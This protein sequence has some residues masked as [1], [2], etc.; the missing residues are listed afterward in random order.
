MINFDLPEDAETYT[1][2]VGRTGRAGAEGRALTFV[3][4][5]QRKE[6]HAMARSLE[7]EGE[8]RRGLG[9]EPRGER[10]ERH[11]H[12]SSNGQRA[13]ASNGGQRNKRPRRR[14]SKSK[15]TAAR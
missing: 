15:A 12:Q 9:A 7:L 14:R 6:T 4:D 8:L 5:D 10:P 13:H 1:H 11:R 2:R 3:L